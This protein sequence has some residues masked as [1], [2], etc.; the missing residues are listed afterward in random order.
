MFGKSFFLLKKNLFL[1]IGNVHS[2]SLGLFS[3]KISIT[4]R[5]S[6]LENICNLLFYFLFN[7]FFKQKD[8]EKTKLLNSNNLENNSFKKYTIQTFYENIILPTSNNIVK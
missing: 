5:N 1:I 3:K 8:S 2:T 4:R 6:K 7:V